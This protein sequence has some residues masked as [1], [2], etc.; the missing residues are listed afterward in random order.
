MRS[1]LT[2]VTEQMIAA[3]HQLLTERVSGDYKARSEAPDDPQTVPVSYTHL[4]LP[5]KA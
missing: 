5:T 2:P 3:A 1:T 4:T